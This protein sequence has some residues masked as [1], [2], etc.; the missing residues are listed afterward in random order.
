[1]FSSLIFLLVSLF[2]LSS[3]FSFAEDTTQKTSDTPS[4]SIHK[5]EEIVVSAT[6]TEEK[7]KDILS[8]ITVITSEE[9]KRYGVQDVSDFLRQV[10]GLYLSDFGS[11]R[12]D[13][14]VSARGNQPTTRGIQILYDSIEYNMA[15]GYIQLLAIPY[16]N[17]E[18]IEIVKNPSSPLYGEFGV[19]GVINIIPRYSNSKL[20]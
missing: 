11:I 1:M 2:L 3:N 5:K 9:I 12:A 20:L 19:G 17:I 7:I 10:P 6:K 14:Y 4:L 13:M 16:G 15:S 18:K 8:N